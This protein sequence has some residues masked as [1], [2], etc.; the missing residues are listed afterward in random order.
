MGKKSLYFLA[1]IG[2]FLAHS[3]QAEDNKI[4]N[5]KQTSLP[6]SSASL[7]TAGT[8]PLAEAVGHYARSRALLISAIREFDAGYKLANPD[9]LMDSKA[10]RA[11]LVTRAT[12]LEK[13][14]DPQARASKGGVSFNPDSRLLAGAK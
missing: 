6:P 5:L 10:F 12:E 8:E 3:A 9:M 13:V 2:L 4:A 11:T 14:L 7:L 1:V